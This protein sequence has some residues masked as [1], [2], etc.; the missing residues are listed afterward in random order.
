MPMRLKL[1][2]AIPFLALLALLATP[3]PAQALNLCLLNCTCGLSATAVPFGGY[4][5]LSGSAATAVGTVTASCQLVVSTG[6]IAQIVSYNLLLSTGQSGSY[7]GRAMA[8]SSGSLGYN[9]S[10]DPGMTTI[11]GDGTGGSQMQGGLL[12]LLILNASVNN[13]YSVY[14]KIPA[15]QRA[16]SGGYGDT[17]TVTMS[18]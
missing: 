8:G 11:W 14:G 9:L 1:A 7:T 4:D 18:F 10:S 16:A 5:P 12:T 6:G 13:S 15:N 3:R 17:I 2:L